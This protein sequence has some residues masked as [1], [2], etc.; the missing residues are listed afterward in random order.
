MLPVGTKTRGTA[1][2]C[3]AIAAHKGR[4]QRA[5]ACAARLV[6]LLESLP[7]CAGERV[8]AELVDKGARRC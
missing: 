6:V 3:A 7:Q 1:V 2:A 5:T 4:L 8:R